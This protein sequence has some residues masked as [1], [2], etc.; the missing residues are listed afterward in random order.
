MTN[1]KFCDMKY[2]NKKARLAAR[3]KWYDALE[4]KDKRCNTRPGSMNK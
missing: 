1:H 2:K 4:E 3:Q